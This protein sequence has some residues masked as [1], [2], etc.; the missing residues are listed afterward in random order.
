MKVEA[1][2]KA[3]RWMQGLRAVVLTGTAEM[4]D[5]CRQSTVSAGSSGISLQALPCPRSTQRS[6]FVD[7]TLFGGYSRI[8]SHSKCRRD[9]SLR[10]SLLKGLQLDGNS[11]T[12]S[13]HTVPV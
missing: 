9:N 7:N 10:L 8:D 12:H 6:R 13:S 2:L 11:Q 4:P 3:R 5:G 1:Y